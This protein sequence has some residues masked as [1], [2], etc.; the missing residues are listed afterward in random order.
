MSRAWGQA[1][2][3]ATIGARPFSDPEYTG[4]PL[5]AFTL[6]IA[7]DSAA[8]I[9][10]IADAIEQALVGP[11]V[12]GVPIIFDM[13]GDPHMGEIRVKDDHAPLD[14]TVKFL[15]AK[16]AETVPDSTPTW[17]SSNEDAATVEA[18]EDGLSATV[19]IGLP[20]E[21]IISAETTETHEGVG[22]P[23][24]VRAVGTVIVEA[25]D[26]TVGSVDFAETPAAQ[27]VSIEPAG[28]TSSA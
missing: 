14:A 10:R 18:S 23:T 5:N 27:E 16:G 12:F 13:K 26:T 7:T 8:E 24:T 15:D 17:E 4:C 1:S 19:T 25:G 9:S 3:G 20:G 21:A 28:E 2:V 22:D 11:P 6:T